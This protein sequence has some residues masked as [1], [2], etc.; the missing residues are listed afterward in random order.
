[1]LVEQKAMMAMEVSN[2]C[3]VLETGNM[4]F[5]GDPATLKSNNDIASAYLG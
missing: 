4:A 1:M 3:Y 5:E 2:Y